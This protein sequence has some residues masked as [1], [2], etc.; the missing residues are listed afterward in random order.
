MGDF[1]SVPSGYNDQLPTY[2]KSSREGLMF[3]LTFSVKISAE[4][5]RLS[6]RDKY[7]LHS[8]EYA[9]MA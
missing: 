4:L 1:T 3:F 6:W 2:V 8:C 7:V 5:R 9:S